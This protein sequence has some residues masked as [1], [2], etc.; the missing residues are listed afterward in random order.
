[1]QINYPSTTIAPSTSYI[2]AYPQ[3][4]G[5]AFTAISVKF[6][7]STLNVNPTRLIIGVYEDNNGYPGTKVAETAE[8]TITSTGVVTANLTAPFAFLSNRFYWIAYHMAN[9]ITLRAFYGYALPAIVE[10]TDAQF[11]AG[12]FICGYN[13]IRSYDSTLPNTFPSD[14]STVLSSSQQFPVMELLI[15]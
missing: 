6:A 11:L 2:W 8:L 7:V 4:I 9:S 1:M 15:Q 14:W 3:L 10:P 13:N 5:M 12:N